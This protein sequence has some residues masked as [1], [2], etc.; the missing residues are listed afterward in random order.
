MREDE[1]EEEKERSRRK[2][3]G[4]RRRRMKRGGAVREPKGKEEGWGEL[5]E[6]KDL[7]K[8]VAER[9][10]KE[11]LAAQ[12]RG[13]RRR[14]GDR[15][16]L[17]PSA[18]RAGGRGAQGGV[19]QVARAAPQADLWRNIGSRFSG[20]LEE[21]ALLEARGAGDDARA[22]AVIRRR[23]WYQ[24]QQRRKRATP[25]LHGNH[26]QNTIDLKQSRGR[27]VY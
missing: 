22:E 5:S 26:G 10:E 1:D 21:A 2:R 9:Q 7:R 8:V 13:S 12:I 20:Q 15:Q 3:E 14:C 23:R 18:V 19:A 24:Q 25:K 27:I 11:D 6:E 17:I 4:K 16:N